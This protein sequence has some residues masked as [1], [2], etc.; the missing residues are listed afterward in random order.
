MFVADLPSA[1]AVPSTA[2]AVESPNLSVLADGVPCDAGVSDLDRHSGLYK[3][4]CH[5]M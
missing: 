1:A 2:T 3:D 4:N 5:E